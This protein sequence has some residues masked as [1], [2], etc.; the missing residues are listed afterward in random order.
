MNWFLSY[1]YDVSLW[2][3]FEKQLIANIHTTVPEPGAS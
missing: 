3:L 2:E 1:A